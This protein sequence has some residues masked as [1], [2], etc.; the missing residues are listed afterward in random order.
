MDLKSLSPEL[1]PLSPI[2]IKITKT[3]K[4]MTYHPSDPTFGNEGDA[5][6]YGSF[7]GLK[8][9]KLP[10]VAKDVFSITE[11]AVHTPDDRGCN[12]VEHAFLD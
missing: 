8:E 12:A 1:A 9:L 6:I 2:T 5:Q 10:P 3:T 7:D 11:S 4:T